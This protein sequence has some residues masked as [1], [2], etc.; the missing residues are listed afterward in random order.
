MKKVC[1]CSG[2]LSLSCTSCSSI[3]AEKE[4]AA[5]LHRSLTAFLLAVPST[6]AAAAKMEKES[7]MKSMRIQST[8]IMASPRSLSLR[9]APAIVCPLLLCFS[10]LAFLCIGFRRGICRRQ[11]FRFCRGICC[12]EGFRFLPCRCH[13]F[14]LCRF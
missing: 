12:R 1:R 3:I 9:K 4:D 5:V 14:R 10:I 8:R 6:A 13:N 11:G 7:T 2:T